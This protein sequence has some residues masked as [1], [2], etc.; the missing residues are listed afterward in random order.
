MSLVGICF[1]ET[2]GEIIYRRSTVANVKDPADTR[3]CWERSRQRDKRRG[4]AT[5][6]CVNLL[7]WMTITENVD[8]GMNGFSRDE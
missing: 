5:S 7:F 3:P 4:C 1:W 2:L 8:T 6:G